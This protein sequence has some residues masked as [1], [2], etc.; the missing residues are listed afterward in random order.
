MP[1]QDISPAEIFLRFTLSPESILFSMA[2]LMLLSKIGKE[3]SSLIPLELF[4]K[5]FGKKLSVGGKAPSSPAR[6]IAWQTQPCT[7]PPCRF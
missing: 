5:N 3:K 6:I 2:W 7:K 4:P 1:S